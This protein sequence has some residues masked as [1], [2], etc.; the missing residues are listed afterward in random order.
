MVLVWIR[1][2]E[3]VR[4]CGVLVRFWI[5]CWGRKGEIDWESKGEV[6]GS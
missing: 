4:E 3:G 1:K 6:F 2:E 5:L